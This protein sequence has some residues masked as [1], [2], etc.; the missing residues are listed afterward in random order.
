[1]PKEVILTEELSG[2]WMYQIYILDGKRCIRIFNPTE[3]GRE[4]YFYVD[5]SL[6]KYR[7]TMMDKEPSL[8]FPIMLNG[9]AYE[10]AGIVILDENG[11]IK[12]RFSLSNLRFIKNKNF[13]IRKIEN[14]SY[15]FF[16]DGKSQGYLN[17]IFNIDKNRVIGY[18]AIFTHNA[19]AEIQILDLETLGVVAAKTNQ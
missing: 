16:I 15:E 10:I 11:E 4:K 12:D 6:C 1:M 9:E 8:R 2:G 3:D 7:A 19:P 17:T 13:D 14:E 18:E 5:T